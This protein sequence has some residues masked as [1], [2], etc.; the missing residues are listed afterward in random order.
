MQTDIRVGLLM[1]GT[2]DNKEPMLRVCPFCGGKAE[3]IDEADDWYSKYALDDEWV[4]IPMRV[5]CRRCGANIQSCDDAKE[6]VIEQWNTRYALDEMIDMTD[7][8]IYTAEEMV[9]ML[10]HIIDKYNHFPPDND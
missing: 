1:G 4:N 5:Q 6:D 3:F 2:M 9:L 8:Q 7:Q 10:M